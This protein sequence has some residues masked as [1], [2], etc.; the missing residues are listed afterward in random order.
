MANPTYSQ[1]G[2]LARVLSNA[3]RG[4][5]DAALSDPTGP[6]MAQNQEQY[7]ISVIGGGRETLADEGS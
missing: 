5:S 1:Q 7:T 2:W 4:G 6:R 3:R